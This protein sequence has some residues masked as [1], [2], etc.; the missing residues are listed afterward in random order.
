MDAFI[1]AGG[2]GTRIN[3]FKKKPKPLIKFN[4]KELIIHIADI[5]KKNNIKKIYILTGY[6]RTNFKYLKKKYKNY[7]IEIFYTGLNST[8]GERLLKIEKLIKEKNFLVTYGDSLANFNIKKNLK[9]H[10]LNKNIV[11]TCLF[12]LKN[13]YGEIILNDEKIESFVEKK[14][15]YVN[16]GFYIINKN[17]FNYKKKLKNFENILLN[18]LAK[19]NK[20]GYVIVNKWQPMDNKM[21]YFEMN[22]I[23][24]KKDYFL[25]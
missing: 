17:I 7:N 22:K 23:L 25:K 12:K 21:N 2:K 11:T 10:K 6:K 3:K 8:T 4:K 5:L 9:K 1:F 14:T 18:I 16:A 13:N 19:K 15:Q 20:L 24:N